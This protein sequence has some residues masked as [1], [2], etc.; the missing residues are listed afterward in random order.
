MLRD[1]LGRSGALQGRSG[2]LW[3]AQGLSGALWGAY[4]P[5]GTLGDAL[6]RF[7]T[8]MK[9]SGT[10]LDARRRFGMLGIGMGCFGTLW[11]K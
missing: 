2:M 1:V 6:E 7:R 11:G 9:R 4:G 10:R 8:L 3:S 5:S